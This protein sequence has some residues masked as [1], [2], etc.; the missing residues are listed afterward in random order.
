MAFKLRNLSTLIITYV[1][2]AYFRQIMIIG[3]KFCLSFNIKIR[4]YD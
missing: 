4:C 2:I 1:L 3:H